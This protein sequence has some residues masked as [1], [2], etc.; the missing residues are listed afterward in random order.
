[1]V[2]ASPPPADAAA[3]LRWLVDRAQIADLLVEM[4]RALDARDGAAYAAL[5]TE[6]GSLRL[7][8]ARQQGQAEL[9][10]G[11]HG[12]LGAYGAVWHLSAN[13]AIEITG[14]EART[15]SYVI[16][17]HRL[18]DDLAEHADMAGWYDAALR[19][20]PDGWRFVSLTAQGVWT[21]GHDALPHA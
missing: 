5:F 17:V 21:S 10:A 13:H 2:T 12:A 11:V 1:M 15:R 16:G 6:D 19:R 18:G 14:D 4:A 8:G 7:P 9:E 20:T 3:Q